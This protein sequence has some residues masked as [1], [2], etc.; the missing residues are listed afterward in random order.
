M[1]FVYL[2]LLSSLGENVAADM[3]KQLFGSLI[4]QDIAFFDDHRTGDLVNRL[5]TDV[6]DFK[7]SFK[8]CVSQG[9]RSGAQA[10]GCFLS[11]Y[12]ISPEMT[13]MM[14][15]VIPAMITV[16]AAVGSSLRKFVVLFTPS[17]YLTRLRDVIT[18]NLVCVF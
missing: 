6:Q 15:V 18:I 5:T 1:T 13:K 9:L 10:L 14:V 4:V 7:S 3:R 2:S 12:F 8:L 11:A 17:A 16:G